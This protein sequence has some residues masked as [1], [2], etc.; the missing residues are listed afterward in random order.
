MAKKTKSKH[1][2][3]RRFG[4]DVYGTGGPSLERRLHVHPGGR[5]KSHQPS[6]YSQQLEEKQKLKAIYGL[7]E[8]QLLRYYREAQ[9]LVGN[10][11]IIYFS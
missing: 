5:R 11:A 2:T 1:K 7:S 9:R 3:S 6:E 4:I 10:P 8:K